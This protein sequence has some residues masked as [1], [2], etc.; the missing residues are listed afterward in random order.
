MDKIKNKIKGNYD[1]Y[2]DHPLISMYLCSN[3]DCI[4]CKKQVL[5][6]E[7]PKKDKALKTHNSI[8]KE[9]TELTNNLEKLSASVKL[10]IERF[11][12]HNFGRIANEVINRFANYDIEIDKVETY[13]SF[14]DCSD[15]SDSKFAFSKI[16]LKVFNHVYA[17]N[18]TDKMFKKFNNKLA[19]DP[20]MYPKEEKTKILYILVLS[21]LY[22][23]RNQIDGRRIAKRILELGFLF[24]PLSQ[25]NVDYLNDPCIDKFLVQMRQNTFDQAESLFLNQAYLNI[26]NNKDMFGLF[27]KRLLESLLLIADKHIFSFLKNVFTHGTVLFNCIS[28]FQL[29]KLIIS[30]YNSMLKPENTF[31]ILEF[32]Y[33]KIFDAEIGRMVSDEIRG[34]NIRKPK[35]KRRLIEIE[36]RSFRFLNE[37]KGFL[38]QNKDSFDALSVVL[39]DLRIIKSCVNNQ[40]DVLELIEVFIV[41]FQH[42]K[43]EF[44]EN[45]MAQ[46]LNCIIFLIVKVKTFDQNFVAFNIKNWDFFSNMILVSQRLEVENDD[47]KKKKRP[48]LNKESEVSKLGAKLAE[49]LY[50]IEDQMAAA[51]H[52]DIV[53]LKKRGFKYE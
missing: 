43:S 29:I 48:K 13:Q 7:L 30:F 52:K 26:R 10:W 47:V 34:L 46:I 5:Q 39:A 16:D 3:Y 44:V 51:G 35:Y 18:F 27:H 49:T 45:V 23:Y 25:F 14:L 22:C 41:M 4:I 6:E 37:Y 1:K 20:L 19:D 38:I 2:K 8:L 33:E 9:N 12:F 42:L 17:C 32:F 53:K 15:L 36:T 50:Q 40:K 28:D 24:K 21:Y 11:G 31:G